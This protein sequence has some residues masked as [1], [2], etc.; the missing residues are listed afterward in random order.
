MKLSLL[1]SLAPPHATLDLHCDLQPAVTF[2]A[3]CKKL[4]PEPASEDTICFQT[5]SKAKGRPPRRREWHV[6]NLPPPRLLQ[7]TRRQL[8]AAL[9]SPKIAFCRN[10]GAAAPRHPGQD[11]RAEKPPHPGPFLLQ[12]GIFFNGAASTNECLGGGDPPGAAISTCGLW[13]SVLVVYLG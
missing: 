10:V 12:P 7:G 5:L 1:G 11:S 8:L 9:L 4:V 13:R 2:A 3:H 6:P